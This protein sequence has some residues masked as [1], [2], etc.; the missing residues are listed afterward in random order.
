MEEGDPLRHVLLPYI[1]VPSSPGLFLASLSV[2]L[3]GSP[4]NYLLP[5]LPPN[6]SRFFSLL[7]DRDPGPLLCHS[8]QEPTRSSGTALPISS[9]CTFFLSS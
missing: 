6:L 9:L 3:A 7:Q 5:A 1:W 4:H 2:I 8:F